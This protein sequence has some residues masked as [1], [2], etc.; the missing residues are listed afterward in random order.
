S[1]APVGWGTVLRRAV[2]LLLP[3]RRPNRRKGW[4]YVVPVVLLIAGVMFATTAETA[5]GT[6]LRN[7]RRGELRELIA[8]RKDEVN[9]LTD[10]RSKLGK[11]V[12][13]DTDRLAKSDGRIRDEQDRAD[14]Y[15]TEAGLTKMHGPGLT[16]A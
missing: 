15:R 14:R 7:D 8:E 11:D 13:K 1:D 4:S 10:R 6:E 2:R 9:G 12:E 3:R 5:R 16:V